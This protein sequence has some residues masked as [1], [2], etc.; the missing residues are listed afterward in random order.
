MPCFRESGES[1]LTQDYLASF[2]LCLAKEK[3]QGLPVSAA[4]IRRTP[5]PNLD[6]RPPPL[7]ANGF[8]LSEHSLDARP[9]PNLP[10]RESIGALHRLAQTPLVAISNLTGNPL[11]VLRAC[12][13]I[14]EFG[15]CE[16]RANTAHLSV[17]ARPQLVEMP[18]QLAA[19]NLCRIDSQSKWLRTVNLADH[20]IQR[21]GDTLNVYG[22]G[23]HRGSCCRTAR[24]IGRGANNR[25]GQALR[26]HAKTRRSYL[27]ADSLPSP[28]GGLAT[29]QRLFRLIC[30]MPGPDS[31]RGRVRLERQ[32]QWPR[33]SVRPAARSATVLA[34]PQLLT[35]PVWSQ[36]LI[37][38]PSTRRSS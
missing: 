29:W 1:D 17:G 24:W 22:R 36:L 7:R 10:R 30:D 6:P 5:D 38:M 18:L 8:I 19:P 25:D 34:C 12:T 37:W 16:L 13:G 21:G 4:A 14:H 15:C 28:S 26:P 27:R 20:H 31:S 35:G 2:W 32:L 23:R 9:S 11:Q 33:T 3:L